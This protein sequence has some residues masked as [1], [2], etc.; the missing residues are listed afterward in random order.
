[1]TIAELEQSGQAAYQEQDYNKAVELFEAAYEMKQTIALNQQLV[2]SLDAAEQF[3]QAFRIATELSWSVYTTLDMQTQFIHIALHAKRPISARKM[4]QQ[5]MTNHDA[6]ESEIN[7]LEEK[8]RVEETVKIK[9]MTRD[10][11]HL[12]DANLN[13]QKQ[14]LTEFEQLPLKEYEFGAQGVL[15]DPFSSA[16]IRSTIFDSLQRLGINH[17][18]DMVSVLGETQVI[19]PAEVGP[20]TN[21]H[22]YQAIMRVLDNIEADLD[23]MLWQGVRQQA[24][25]LL[26]IMY[27]FLDDGIEDPRVWVQDLLALLTGMNEGQS[28]PKQQQWLQAS[29]KAIEEAFGF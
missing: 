19:V 26:Q 17:T 11:Y 29:L 14:R 2:A 9:Q 27:P 1:M 13:D 23:P 3:E 16:L 5:V 22:T 12:G 25:V 6:L 4:L 20:L 7:G 15:T 21:M 24:E 18:I 8:L 10:F 28:S